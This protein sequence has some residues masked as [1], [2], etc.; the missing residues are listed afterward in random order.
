MLYIDVSIN[1]LYFICF[2]IQFFAIKNGERTNEKER[3][4]TKSSFQFR[5]KFL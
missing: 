1:K 2:V 4:R 5:S 3:I